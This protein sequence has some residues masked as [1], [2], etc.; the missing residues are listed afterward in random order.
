MHKIAEVNFGIS[1]IKSS[2][3]T[4]R[5]RGLFFIGD[6]C[7]CIAELCAPSTTK[8]SKNPLLWKIIALGWHSY[9]LIAKHT[10]LIITLS[11]GM[12]A[13]LTGKVVLDSWVCDGSRLG[14]TGATEGFQLNWLG[15]FTEGEWVISAILTGLTQLLDIWDTRPHG[16]GFRCLHLASLNSHCCLRLPYVAAYR[17]CCL[18]I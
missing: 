13:F 9:S 18:Q 11:I 17:K 10:V 15:G 3:L 4:T 16:H 5:P 12:S 7:S 8:I 1:A 6:A 2:N 14:H